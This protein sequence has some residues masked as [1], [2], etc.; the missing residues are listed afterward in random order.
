MNPERK[1]GRTK[2]TR[3]RLKDFNVLQSLKT[4]DFHCLCGKE[5]Y[6]SREAAEFALRAINARRIIQYGVPAEREVYECPEVLGADVWHLTSSERGQKNFGLA[7][8]RAER[9]E[10][11]K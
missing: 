2:R 10:A 3:D 9:E 7:G 11:K 5:V 6:Y 4:R 1:H 8:L